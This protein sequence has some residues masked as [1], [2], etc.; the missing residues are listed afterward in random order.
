[1]WSQGCSQCEVWA[2]SSIIWIL[3]STATSSAG[4]RCVS[5]G[6]RESEFVVFVP[7]NEWNSEPQ[8]AF[9][10]HCLTNSMLFQWVYFLFVKWPP[11]LPFTLACGTIVLLVMPL[12]EQQ[13]LLLKWLLLSLC[14]HLS[15]QVG[16]ISS[17]A[18]ILLVLLPVLCLVY[19]LTERQVADAVGF[20]CKLLSFTTDFSTWKYFS[21]LTLSMHWCLK[22]A[23]PSV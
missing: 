10:S 3:F 16:R 13:H 8:Q 17:P 20:T 4:W 14:S 2:G 5:N 6:R 18:N 21:T 9:S 15:A 11:C 19:C 22:A 7:R 23:M 12:W 1:M